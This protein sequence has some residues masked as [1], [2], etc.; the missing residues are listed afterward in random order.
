MSAPS[1]FAVINTVADVYGCDPSSI[2]ARGR[3]EPQATAR[4]LVMRLLSGPLGLGVTET[5][6]LTGR[7][8]ASVCHARKRV[9]DLYWS[10]AF[11]KARMRLVVDRLGLS[12]SVLLD[13]GPSATPPRI[14]RHRLRVD[15]WNLTEPQRDVVCELLSVLTDDARREDLDRFMSGQLALAVSEAKPKWALTDSR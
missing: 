10:S 14:P 8:H 13:P 6:R 12:D 4:A 2:L 5:G 11:D 1:P 9:S 3:C 15:L 7:N